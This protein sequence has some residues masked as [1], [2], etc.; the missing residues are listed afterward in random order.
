MHGVRGVRKAR[1]SIVRSTSMASMAVCAALCPNLRTCPHMP[2]PGHVWACVLF[3]GA[4][5]L[6]SRV[7]EG[8][9]CGA[10]V[11]FGCLLLKSRKTLIIRGKTPR[12]P[13]G[14]KMGMCTLK[15]QIRAQIF[16]AERCFSSA[17]TCSSSSAPA[18]CFLEE[19][20][21]DFCGRFFDD[22]INRSDRSINIFFQARPSGPLGEGRCQ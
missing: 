4:C 16:I 17:A 20:D 3:R 14:P 6:G 21:D 11:L 19:D 18:R 9:M 7:L 10:C 13:R 5:V 15:F 1:L 22:D 12:T 8:G 2:R